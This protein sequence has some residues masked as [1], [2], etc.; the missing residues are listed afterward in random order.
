MVIVDI[1]L[2]TI[3]FTASPD[4]GQV[5]EHVLIGS[6]TPRGTYVLQQRL[7][8]D[9][10]YG[11]DILQFREDPTEVYAI[12][13]VWNGRPAEHR[14]MRIRSDK[15]ADR[16]ITKGCINVTPEVYARLLACCS[17][18]TLVIK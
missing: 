6:D 11:G 17:Q 16:K 18:E 9:P 12:H 4:A 2:A 10:L 3:C 13:R 15:A 5:C 7:V 14:E 8:D 1:A